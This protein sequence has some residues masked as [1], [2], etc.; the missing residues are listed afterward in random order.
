MVKII[1]I[2]NTVVHQQWCA[3]YNLNLQSRD[4]CS[5]PMS[6]VML[7]NPMERLV[8]LVYAVEPF[9]GVILAIPLRVK[10]NLVS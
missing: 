10:G 2:T 7:A 5:Q 6:N 1:W 8:E 3:L 9:K 4:A